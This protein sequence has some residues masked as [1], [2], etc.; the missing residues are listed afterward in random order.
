MSLFAASIAHAQ[1]GVDFLPSG[2]AAVQLQ[3]GK[4]STASILKHTF[5]PAV[6]IQAQISALQNWV[7]D[8]H[9]QKTPCVCL[10]SGDDCNV[11]QVEKPE[12]EAAE[13]IPALTWRVKDLLG[14]DVGS[15]VVDSYPMPKSSKNNTQQVSVVCAHESVVKSYVDSI[16]SVGLKLVAIDTHDLVGK[17]IPCIQHGV[18]QTQAVLTLEEKN[19]SL[20]IFHDGDL[21]VSRDLKIGVE[22]VALASADDQSVYDSLFLEIQR[23]LDYFESYYGLGSISCLHLFPQIPETEKMA[24]YLQN[25]TSFD[26]DFIGFGGEQSGNNAVLEPQCFHAYCAALRGVAL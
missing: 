17:N 15:A 11:Y 14:Y 8:H 1:I 13:M 4:K 20:S 3:T 9:L 12:V 26:I 7:R 2:V 23:S 6:G 18:G 16:K 21:Y 24:R 5:I 25:L 22:Q 19:G 10:I